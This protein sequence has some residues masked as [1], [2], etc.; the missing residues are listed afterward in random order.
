MIVDGFEQRK[1]TNDTDLYA[2]T[3]FVRNIIRS[4]WEEDVMR[5]SVDVHDIQL[6]DKETQRSKSLLL[7]PGTTSRVSNYKHYRQ[8]MF[9]RQRL[10][11][12]KAKL[13]HIMWGFQC[14]QPTQTRGTMEYESWTVLEELL[15]ASDKTLG[16]HMAMFAQRS[17]L[18]QADAADRQARSSGQLTKIATFIVPCTFVASIFSMNGEFAAGERFFYVYWVVSIPITVLLLI[19]VMVNDPDRDRY[20]RNILL[21]LIRLM[22]RLISRLSDDEEEEVD[23]MGKAGEKD[24][25]KTWTLRKRRQR[26]QHEQ[27]TE[28]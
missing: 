14:R 3:M 5:E 22:S 9:Q 8:L 28:P 1:F 12:K 7:S 27:G 4:I 20:L 6:Y 16:D 10:R 26:K 17:A 11:E 19:W 24:Q 15:E 13:R 2:A 21:W 23:T 25:S 18:L